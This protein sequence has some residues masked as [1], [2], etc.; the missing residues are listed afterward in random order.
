VFFAF[1]WNLRDPFLSDDYILVSRA[2]MNTPSI[3]W[4]FKNPG[5]D[6]SFRPIGFL[7]FSVV[8]HF[9]GT[10][11]WKWHICGLML[12]LLNCALLYL[13]TWRLWRNL[14]IS[15]G[16]L[17]LF[18]LRGTRPEV[19]VWT[20]GSFDSL[21]CFFVLL[22][23]CWVFQP[24]S[25]QR[26][27]VSLVVI[28]GLVVLAIW[29]KES[30]YALPFMLGGFAYAARRQ[31]QPAIRRSFLWAVLV[32]AALLTHRFILFGGPG[33]YVNP[34]TGR[35]AI[36]S[37]NILSV[38]KALLLRLW[39]V[40]MFPVDWDAG[41]RWSLTL[42]AALTGLAFAG[43]MA[44]AD[45]GSFRNSAA[46]IAMT[47]FAIL[48]AIHLALIGPSELGSRIL[49]LPSV[50][51]LCNVRISNVVDQIAVQAEIDSGCAGC[52]R[53]GCLDAQSCGVA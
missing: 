26:W 18:G 51:V 38:A 41:D 15:L 12:H 36:F 1:C 6:G 5:G 23:L 40:L 20:A 13:L 52:F 25:E 17:L 19:V 33:G 43:L 50:G 47:A 34:Q 39:A 42:C 2:S 9:G 45:S 46:M 35:S 31:A 11:P 21:A 30:G 49:Y 3:T 24:A 10:E 29:S 7:Y 4:Y 53:L 8:S 22:T 28:A 16:S 44:A 14:T 27:F 32:C 48:P 37:L